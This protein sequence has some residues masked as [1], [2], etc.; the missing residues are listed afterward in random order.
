MCDKK[1][2]HGDSIPFHVA[3]YVNLGIHAYKESYIG[4]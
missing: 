3:C 2:V 4:H 1:G